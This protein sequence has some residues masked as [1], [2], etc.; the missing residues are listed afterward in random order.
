LA[1]AADAMPRIL[2][3]DIDALLVDYY[4]K[5]ISGAGMDPNITGRL[6]FA[7][8]R[9]DPGY[10][11]IKKIALFRLTKAS[12]G[13]A[14]GL[15]I[16][17]YISRKFANEVDLGVTYTNS[18]SSTL[19]LAKIPMVMNNDNDTIYAAASV[20]GKSDVRA[21]R[22][23]RIKNTLELDRVQVS[24]NFLPEIT[25]RSDIK[26]VN[27]PSNFVFDDSGNLADLS[28]SISKSLCP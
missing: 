13:N 12:H 28:Y 4:G 5:E 9:R 8:H 7:P 1:E 27:E 19:S 11:D 14:T 3:H 2:F 23:I 10:P 16:A 24:E 15:G 26:I 17:D 25:D 6:L 18:L 21:V 22:I 20:C